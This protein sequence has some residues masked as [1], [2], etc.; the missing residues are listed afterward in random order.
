MTMLKH[1]G[2]KARLFEARGEVEA[3]QR[4][5]LR[6]LH[7]DRVAVDERGRGLPG[8]DRRREV[9]RRDQPD[10]AERAVDGVRDAAGQHLLEPLAGRAAA[11]RRSR[12]GRP[13]T[14]AA[15]PRAPRGS[16]CPSRASCPGRS[17]PRAVSTMSAAL[18]R[19]AP[20]FA[21]GVR[22][23]SGKAASA[24]ATAAFT[25]SSPEAGNSPITSD[26]RH[27]PR[28]SYVRPETL[29]RHSPPMKL[30]SAGRAGASRTSDMDLAPSR[31]QQFLR[32][33]DGVRQ[34]AD[35]RNV[36]L[37]NV[38]RLEREVVRRDE[39]GAGEQHAAG[40]D[41]V[42]RAAATRRA[43]RTSCA[44]ARSRSRRRR[45]RCRRRPRS[46]GGSRAARSQSSGTSTAGPSAH[47]PAKIFAWGM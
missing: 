40:R 20:R 47:A 8:G 32:R 25:S 29:G 2:G 18:F 7:H 10:D 35:A 3:G 24:A 27:G 31:G 15:P 37:D 19:I 41:G 12:S 30:A 28:F 17:A 22:A 45:A 44:C 1:A 5:L 11:P 38:A 16:A 23:H 21:A 26:G 4:R 43:R 39:A 36:D 33:D 9:P 13:A 46:G 14:S 34:G 6:E 42:R